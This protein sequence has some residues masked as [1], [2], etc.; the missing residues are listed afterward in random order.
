MER[1]KIQGNRAGS[2]PLASTEGDL[3]LVLK[4]WGTGTRL[5]L[6]KRMKRPRVQ[7]PRMGDDP[8]S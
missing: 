3:R 7:D 6:F 1:G 5:P 8:E 2:K 4:D